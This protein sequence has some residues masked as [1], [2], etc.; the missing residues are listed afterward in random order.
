MEEEA[1]GKKKGGKIEERGRGKSKKVG[2]R[3]IVGRPG[4]GRGKGEMEGK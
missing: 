2:K 4:R 1:E 3:K